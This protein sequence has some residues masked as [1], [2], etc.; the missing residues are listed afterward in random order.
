MNIVPTLTRGP[1]ILLTALI[2]G[3]FA[4]ACTPKVQIAP[5]NE[6]ITVNLNVKIQ[7]EIFVKVDKDVDALF[8][9]GGLF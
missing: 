5:S 3:M 9:D 4:I 7:H 2:L 6:P 8:D 1:L